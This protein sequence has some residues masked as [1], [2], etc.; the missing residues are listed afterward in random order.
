MS[1]S[2]PQGRWV[3]SSVKQEDI[4]RLREV[5]YLIVDIQHRLPAPGQV[6]PTP[7]PNEGV[8]FV[9]HFLRGL[10][11]PLHPF[12]RGSCFIM[13][14]IFMIWLQTLSSISR[15][16]LSCAR[17][18]ST[19]PHTSAYGSSLQCEAEDDRGATC[20]VRRC[21]NKKE[22]RCSMARG[23]FLG[24]IRC[25]ATE[26]VLCH[27]SQRHKVGGCPRLPSGPSFSTGV[28]DQCRTGLRIC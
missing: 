19:S 2:N 11:F 13:G 7:E 9:S 20:G 23:L 27:G 16:S 5:G 26:V 18:F 22:H 10:G 28:M 15:R 8:I 12:I 6:I 25:M 4:A 24:S 3:A 14:W 17:L 21:H 1:G